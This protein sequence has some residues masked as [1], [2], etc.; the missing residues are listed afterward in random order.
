MSRLNALISSHT[1][2]LALCEIFFCSADPPQ[3]SENESCHCGKQNH[4]PV[5]IFR[6]PRCNGT[7]DRV[8]KKAGIG[9]GH[10]CK[11]RPCASASLPRLL[12]I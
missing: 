3:P 6:S 11:Q 8:S 5:Y 2:E 12:V 10:C 9:I 7:E 4:L 1:A